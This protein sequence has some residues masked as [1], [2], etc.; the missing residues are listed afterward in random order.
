MFD[1]LTDRLSERRRVIAFDFPGFGK[2]FTPTEPWSVDDYADLTAE[3]LRQ[4]GQPVDVLAHSFGAR[5][6]IKLAARGEKYLDKLL[7]TGAAGVKPKRSLGYYRKIAT[8]KLLRRFGDAEKL[9]QKY[10]SPDYLKLNPVMRESF[11]KVVGED[12]TPLL[13]QVRRPTL[14]VFGKN[15]TETPPYMA[16]IMQKNIKGSA[17]VWFDAGHF[18]FLECPARFYAVAN[19]FFSEERRTL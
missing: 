6:A 15:D 8:Y 13:K 7:L 2:S 17:L 18:C 4:I 11:K 3:V 12:L 5:V 19:A 1:G 16:K 14:L 9:R 10:A